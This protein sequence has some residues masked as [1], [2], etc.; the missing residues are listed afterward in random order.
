[1]RSTP[2]PTPLRFIGLAI[3][4]AAVVAALGGVLA[5]LT[6]APALA[7]AASTIEVTSASDSDTGTSCP[8]PTSCTLRRAIEAAN[9]LPGGDPATIVFNVA[10]FPAATPA[11]IA[12]NSI[13]LPPV[14]RANVVI[15]AAPAGVIVDGGGVAGMGDGIVL[16]G[17]ANVVRGL[18]IQHFTGACVVLTGDHARAGGDP[19][20]R[21]GLRVNG[22]A[23]GVALRG[24]GTSLAGSTIGFAATSDDSAPVG[25][26][27]Q[28]AGPDG[29]VG[30]PDGSAS[31]GNVIGNATTGVRVGP[32]TG[33]T[34]TGAIVGGNTIGRAPGGGT[35][36][37]STG[38][39]ISQPSLG[40]VVLRNLIANAATGIVVAPDLGGVSTLGNRFRSNRFLGLSGLAIDLGAD[41][42][43][44]PNDPGD[45]DGGPNGM[46]NWPALTRAVQGRI[47]GSAGSSCAGCQI[48][49]YIALHQAGLEY[50]SEPL[51]TPLAIADSTGKFSFESP[52]V[53]PGQWV[54]AIA[55][56]ANGN[57]SEFGPAI[58]VGAGVTQC[59]NITLA[60][61]WTHS[62]FFGNASQ[63]IFSGVPGDDGKISA[64]YHLEP[65]G[66]YTRW[67]RDTIAG[68][69]L[70]TLNPGE[71][72]WFLT[73]ADVTLPGGFSLTSPIPVALHTGWNDIVYLGGAGGVGETLA[74]LGGGYSNVY[75]YV[76]DTDG[77]GWQEYGAPAFPS[78]SRDFDQFQP[79]GAYRIVA[80]QDGTLVPLQP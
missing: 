62:G 50:G 52:P 37:V 33:P 14:N 9:A 65:D 40:T 5:S 36:A 71:A 76:H 63:Q 16:N 10:T 18:R 20:A 54:T 73:D 59:G 53:T 13:A 48:E 34:F 78:W 7:Q 60:A 32:G 31:L 43:M 46:L 51:P 24:V 15:D 55:T 67:L 1:V 44:N 11:T 12:V 19:A 61:G 2:C 79:C 66:T 30:T 45:A 27:V 75:Q 74:G 72:Y 21:Q 56:D 68:R 77:S 70:T 41:G 49:L 17:S 39:Y 26:A 35:A 23:T 3:L 4:L 38:V 25:V 57:T 80:T 8:S 28:I 22:C 47:E 29:L 64:I 42:K 6:S 58:R 69:T